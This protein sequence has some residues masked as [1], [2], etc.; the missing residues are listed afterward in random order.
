MAYSFYQQLWPVGEFQFFVIRNVN[1]ID[2]SDFLRH[3]NDGH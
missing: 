2:G 1:T 3:G